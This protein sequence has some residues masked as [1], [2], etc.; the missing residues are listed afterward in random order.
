MFG[1][2]YGQEKDKKRIE[3]LKIKLKNDPNNLEIKIELK[4]A[5]E[6]YE[7]RRYK[8]MVSYSRL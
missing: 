7:E 2:Y 6:Y 5:I 8:A 3:D 1:G 4:K